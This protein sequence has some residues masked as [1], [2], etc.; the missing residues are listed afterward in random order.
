MGL[1]LTPLCVLFLTLFTV[2]LLKDTLW[3]DGVDFVVGA[4]DHEP[5]DSYI[6]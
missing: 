6:A 3:E 4:H 2:K 1:E 5:R